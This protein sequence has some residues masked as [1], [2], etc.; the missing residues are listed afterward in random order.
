MQSTYSGRGSSSKNFA[1][2]GFI[3]VELGKNTGNDIGGT[4]RNVNERAW[5]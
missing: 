2:L 4:A 3:V 1:L 5:M